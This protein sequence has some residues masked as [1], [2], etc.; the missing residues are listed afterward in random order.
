MIAAVSATAQAVLDLLLPRVCAACDELMPSAEQGTVCSP[1]WVRLPLL[2]Y[3][4]CDRCGHPTGGR[5]C[6][7]CDTLPR[8]IRAARSVCWVPHPTASG[9]VHALKY[10]GWQRTATGL[11][12]RMARLTW[13]DDVRRE[14]TAI[15]PI[16]LAPVRERERGF[17]QAERIAASVAAHWRIPVW[18]NVV[19]RQRATMTQTR[20]TPGERSANVHDAFAVSLEM[21]DQL[22]GAHLVVVDDVMTTGA[23]LNACATALFAA[24]ARTL[25]YATFGRARAS[26]DR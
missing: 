7:F 21:R 19:R 13:P 16:P 18:A 11:G 2:P 25:S 14:R 6:R 5:D 12:E 3:P 9:I 24:G 20:L 15:I 10:H 4:Q 22:R 23:T 26:G 1:C 17:N 8:F